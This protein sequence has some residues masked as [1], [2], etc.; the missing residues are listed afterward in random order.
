MGRLRARTHTQTHTTHPPTPRTV[1]VNS[2]CCSAA[3]DKCLDFPLGPCNRV[4]PQKAGNDCVQKTCVVKHCFGW[5]R[6]DPKQCH[7]EPDD[8]FAAGTDLNN[9]SLSSPRKDVRK[10]KKKKRKKYNFAPTEVRSSALGQSRWLA[11][12]LWRKRYNRGALLVGP[13]DVVSLCVNRSFVYVCMD[14]FHH[15]NESR[16]N[17]R[18]CEV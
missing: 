3:L 12:Y 7:V 5:H 13:S 2:T 11:V 16:L 14:R 10:S 8:L 18:T 17:R 4:P 6:S 1:S 15:S 9:C